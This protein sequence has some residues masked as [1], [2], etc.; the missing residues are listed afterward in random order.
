MGHGDAR[1]YVQETNIGK[2][3]KARAAHHK[4]ILADAKKVDASDNL[5][6]KPAE[7]QLMVM[8]PNRICS[9][10]CKNRG[11]RRAVSGRSSTRFQRW[12]GATC[13]MVPTTLLT[14]MV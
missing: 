3:M 13:R 6:V 5:V 7:N 14:A 8:F 9:E 10:R 2:A 12:R 1:S 4:T 11:S